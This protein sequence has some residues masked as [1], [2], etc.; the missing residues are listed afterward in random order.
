MTSSDWIA[1]AAL[2]VTALSLFL[3]YKDRIASS[4]SLLHQKQI[5]LV[6]E[7]SPHFGV[8]TYE[9]SHLFLPV[10]DERDKR[11]VEVARERVD[12]AFVALVDLSLAKFVILPTSLNDIFSD[13]K[14]AA[15]DLYLYELQT[16]R[17]QW[18]QSIVGELD[19]EVKRCALAFIHA[20]RNTLGI[21]VLISAQAKAG[22]LDRRHAGIL[23]KRE[24]GH[25]PRL[26]TRDPDAAIHEFFKDKGAK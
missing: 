1:I 3:T 11:F 24:F 2:A 16:P 10:L 8:L 22:A 7:L 5:E 23:L 6:R 15:D 17:S 19:D 18:D 13:F 4:R 12:G 26:T 25:I 9:I 21:S 20:T 14:S